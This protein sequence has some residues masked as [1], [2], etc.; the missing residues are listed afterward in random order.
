MCIDPSLTHIAPAPLNRFF[1]E[2]GASRVNLRDQN[3]SCIMTKQSRGIEDF[4]SESTRSNQA[5]AALTAYNSIREFFLKPE[6]RDDALSALQCLVQRHPDFA[7]AHS[8][9]G[10]LLNERGEHANA[11]AHLE[12]AVSLD[13]RNGPFLKSLADF[14]YVTLRR[15]NEA[16]DLYSRVLS[17]D[18]GDV[19]TLLTLGNIHIEIQRFDK[20]KVYYERVLAREP[21]NPMASQMLAALLKAPMSAPEEQDPE[22]AYR[23]ATQLAQNGK[24]GD[25]ILKLERLVGSHPGN[26]L[27]WNDLGVLY[28]GSGKKSDALACYE[29]SVAL[30]PKDTT[31]LKNLADYYFIEQGRTEDAL[32]IY[33]QVL[34]IEP[35]DQ[36]SLIA[37]GSICSRSYRPDTEGSL[38]PSSGRNLKRSRPQSQPG[39]IR[40]GIMG[41]GEVGS[42]HLD[43][44]QRNADV[45]CIGV[46]DPA[47]AEQL[48]Q[49]GLRVFDSE[50]ELID[51]SDAIVISTPSHTHADL[52]AKVLRKNKHLFLEKPIDMNLQAARELVELGK[53]ATSVKQMGFVLRFGEGRCRLRELILSGALGRPVCY[54][55]NFPITAG[56]NAE[57]IHRKELGGGIVIEGLSHA[58]DWGRYTFGE[59]TGWRSNLFK[60]KPGNY[61]APDTGNVVFEFEQNDKMMMTFSWA[62]PDTGWSQVGIRDFKVVGPNGFVY[63]YGEEMKVFHGGVE[64]AVYPWPNGWGASG[65]AYNSELVHFMDCIR[66]NAEPRSGLED[67]YKALIPLLDCVNS[68]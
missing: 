53:N 26:A 20:A 68:T 31:A 58:V 18:P 56:A 44:L 3:R 60:F 45:E 21:G 36:E 50:E 30:N 59:L 35:G 49:R 41:I 7:P 25:A 63:I 32:R 29:R 48:A 13:P 17:I 55:E 28:Y 65:E 66:G 14:Y 9:L 43:N 4:F 34:A 67:G 57:W 54:I 10:M 5:A 12:K 22:P 62:M 42:V 46:F 51:A 6:K 38:N 33:H 11:C 47:K 19:Q 61:N 2:E 8:S 52:A 16:V 40:F 1:I 23:E 27:A 15:L 39:L 37:F 24:T 64:K